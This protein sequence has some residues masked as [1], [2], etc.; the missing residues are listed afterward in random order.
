[1]RVLAVMVFG[2]VLLQFHE[3]ILVFLRLFIYN[4]SC[5]TQFHE[6]QYSRTGTTFISNEQKNK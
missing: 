5:S 6:V 1:M 4:A 3:Q 2:L